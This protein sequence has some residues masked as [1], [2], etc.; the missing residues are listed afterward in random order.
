MRTRCVG[1]WCGAFVLAMLALWIG[2]RPHAPPHGE[3]AS[4]LEL[5]ETTQAPP[6]FARALAPRKF[7]FPR[8]HG[9][10]PD[11]QTEWWY[12]TG[13]LETSEGA[14]LG[15]QLTFFRRG[16]NPQAAARVP[17]LA[18]NEVYFAHFAI[19]DIAGG[20]HP[21]FERFSRSALGLAG[22]SGDP[23]RVW[24][25]D[26]EARSLDHAGGQLRLVAREGGW[27]LDLRLEALKPVVAHGL[28]GLSPKSEAPGNASYY[29]S[30]TRL[31]TV[32]EVTLDGEPL[33]VSG[34]SWFDH[35][36]STSA[37]GPQAVGWDW[38]S[39]QLADER[40]LMLFQIRNADGSLD[41][42]S[43]GTLIEAD[44]R[45]RALRRD[46]IELKVETWWRSPSTGA[47][48]PARWRVAIP[49]ELIQLTV[50]PLLA[51][52]EMRV[53]FPYWEG[54]VR[55]SGTSRGRPIQG[56]G[57]LEMTGYERSMQGV[58]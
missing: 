22:A 55:V 23:F 44:G 16:L 32:G 18:A 58:F 4:P 9:P 11:Y 25:E 29:L 14:L 40:D 26:W 52:Q 27:S 31:R 10:H 28:G 41:P 43:G 35:E 49:G 42:V 30:R 34:E 47:R 20:R 12:Y 53:S 48:Y 37:L 57:Y 46:P 54:A 56:Q 3:A 15:Y 6:A 51:D 38:F 39:L 45:A 5:A 7:S 1:L 36:W 24:L 17:R 19:S 2:L 33:S 8:D 13:N 50:E 21:F